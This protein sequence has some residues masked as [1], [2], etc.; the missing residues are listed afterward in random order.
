MRSDTCIP[1]VTIASRHVVLTLLSGTNSDGYPKE[2]L[3]LLSEIGLPIT[4][5]SSHTTGRTDRV[6]GDSADL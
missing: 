5:E 4:E 6:S 2:S 1:V 3:V